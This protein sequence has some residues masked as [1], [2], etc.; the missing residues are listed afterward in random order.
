MTKIGNIKK[1]INPILS[2][3]RFGSCQVEAGTDIYVLLKLIGHSV[4]AM[5]GNNVTVF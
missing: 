4:L 3:T 1:I 2:D 5:S